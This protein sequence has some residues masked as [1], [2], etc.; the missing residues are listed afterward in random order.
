[1]K[2]NAE[3]NHPDA[4]VAAVMEMMLDPAFRQEVCEAT[5]ALDHSVEVEEY[6]DGG[7]LVVVDRLMPSDVP[8]F[9][10]KMIGETISIRQT[11]EWAEPGDDS[12]RTAD[13][14]ITI[15]GQP[16]RMDGTMVLGPGAQG[17]GARLVIEGDV[18]VRV[19]FI[20]KKIEAELAK[21]IL[22][23]V[24]EEQEVGDIWLADH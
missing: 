19:P 1:M 21:G 18:A 16:A 3:I 24:D 23:V 5:H 6:E 2:L 8:D 17:A 15:K 4:T 9:I 11:E 22:A 10:K 7:A 13:V 14:K 12:R 20:G